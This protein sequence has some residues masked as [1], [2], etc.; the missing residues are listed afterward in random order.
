MNNIKYNLS[1]YKKFLF[2]PFQ[3]NYFL[4]S[5]NKGGGEVS[6]KLFHNLFERDSSHVANLRETPKIN[7]FY[8][9]EV[10]GRVFQKLLLC[11]MKLLQPL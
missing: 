6:W 5:I 2:P 3:F 11:L 8:L 10:A 9:Q 4:D 1:N 7:K